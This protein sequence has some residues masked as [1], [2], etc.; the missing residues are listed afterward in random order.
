M[1]GLPQVRCTPECSCGGF[2]HVNTRPWSPPKLEQHGRKPPTCQQ[3]LLSRP[4]PSARNQPTLIMGEGPP[5]TSLRSLPCVLD[6]YN[7]FIEANRIE[8]SRER[9]KTLRKLVRKERRT[10][11]KGRLHWRAHCP[12][13]PGVQGHRFPVTLEEPF[14]TLG[15]SFSRVRGERSEGR[16]Q[17][18]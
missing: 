4:G 1:P 13:R 18:P 11:A 6:K 5:P 3:G 9:L 15:L 7:D 14:S 12:R 8:D 10:W 17:T 16:F 2:G